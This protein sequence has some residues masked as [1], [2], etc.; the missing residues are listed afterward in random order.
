MEGTETEKSRDFKAT[1]GF[2]Y[3][4]QLRI[5]KSRA[6]FNADGQLV[7][8]AWKIPLKTCLTTLR[9][10]I[11]SLQQTIILITY[12]RSNCRN[13]PIPRGRFPAGR[14]VGSRVSY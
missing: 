4:W 2:P 14:Y 6:D 3:S 1:H 7:Q 10:L 11:I 12:G 8:G 9:R 5:D 13:R